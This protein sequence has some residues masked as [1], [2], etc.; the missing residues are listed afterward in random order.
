MAPPIGI[1]EWIA[2]QVQGN[3]PCARYGISINT[4]VLAIVIDCSLVLVQNFAG[5][6]IPWLSWGGEQ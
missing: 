6:D 1:A 5:V 3:I 4:F 2:P